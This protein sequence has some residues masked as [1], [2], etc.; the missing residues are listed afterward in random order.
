M[1]LLYV[2]SSRSDKKGVFPFC[3]ALL[4]LQSLILIHQAGQSSRKPS[5]MQAGR[6]TPAPC[7][8]MQKSRDFKSGQHLEG[9][10]GDSALEGNHL[11]KLA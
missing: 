11:P 8:R 4:D 2:K 5:P 1:N 10:Q 9:K 3:N 6:K 7:Y